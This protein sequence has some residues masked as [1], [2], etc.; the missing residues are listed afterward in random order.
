[1]VID[2]SQ[3]NVYSGQ[4][5]REVLEIRNTYLS[6]SS[7]SCSLAQFSDFNLLNN[8]FSSQQRLSSTLMP[9]AT[10]FTFTYTVKELAKAISIEQAVFRCTTG[11]WTSSD[12]F[13][14]RSCL[15]AILLFGLKMIWI[16]EE[17]MS[18]SDSST[19]LRS[20]PYLHKL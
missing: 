4:R 8:T 19:M 14:F 15:P 12:A 10:A 2:S 6:V 13:L 9:S 7:F 1:M 3:Q 5:I 17:K 18:A 20:G 16:L 11:F